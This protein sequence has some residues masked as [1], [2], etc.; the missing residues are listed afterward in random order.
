VTSGWLLLLLVPGLLVELF[1]AWTLLDWKSGLDNYQRQ[2]DRDRSRCYACLT[3]ASV[4]SFG[5][6]SS[7]SFCS[8]HRA[9]YELIHDLES[10]VI[11]S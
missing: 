6:N 4:M 11:E 10:K 7:S 5:R 8:Y 2:I 3:G 9:H 1:F